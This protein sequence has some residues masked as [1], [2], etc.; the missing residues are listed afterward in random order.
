M[1]DSAGKEAAIARS[2]VSY[3]VRVVSVRQDT[4]QTDVYET[5][6]TAC[7]RHD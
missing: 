7:L 1:P 6:Q 5:A 4:F 2:S 3:G